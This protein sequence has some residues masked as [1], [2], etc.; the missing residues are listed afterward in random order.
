E[1]VLP[2]ERFK[3]EEQSDK[4]KVLISPFI[5]RRTKEE[6]AKDLPELTE[7]TIFCDMSEDQYR[8]YES[9][10]SKIRNI[11]MEN[12]RQSGIERSSI[13][14]LQSLTK[15]RQ[16]A[17]HPKMVDDEYISESGKF[18]EIARN[19]ENVVAEGHKALVFSSFI[20]H[21]D[22]FT[23]YCDQKSI[24]YSM[25]TGETRDRKG[26]VNEFQDNEDVK[27]FFISLKAGGVGLN[28]TAA[29]YVFILDPWWNPA[30]EQQAL[31]RAHRIGQK[32]NV[33]V[34]RFIAKDTIE[35]KIMKLQEKKSKLAD[36][37]VNNNP[38]KGIDKEEIMELLD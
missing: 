22:L 24:P 12:I 31:S 30:A 28:L 7:Q 33:F 36:V 10:K 17:N 25:L 9:E 14:I 18:E 37:F 34:Y 2:I 26:K 20:K 8:Y 27:I 11:L 4:L 15:L 35:E 23:E 19:L 5:L 6:V 32:K 38:F 21:L 29:D 13:L 16:M 1:F 3:N